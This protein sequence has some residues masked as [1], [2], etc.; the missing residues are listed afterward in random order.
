MPADFHHKIYI[1]PKYSRGQYRALMTTL[2]NALGFET[3]D[4]AKFR[5]HILQLLYTS[6]WKAVHQAFPHVSR[7]TVYRWKK[8]YEGS[9]KRLSSL[10]PQATRPV[11]LRQMQTPVSMVEYIRKLRQDYPR[12]GKDK[13]K[14]FLDVF[15]RENSL[16]PICPTTIGKLIKR[17]NFFF[18]KK[19]SG[20][21]KKRKSASRSRV[22][23]CPKGV[24]LGYLQL[25]GIKVWYTNKYYYLL[26][27][28]EI[29]SRQGF[30][31]AVPGFSSSWARLFLQQVMTQV[32]YPVSV[33]QTD[34]GSEFLA[35]FDQAARELGLT[36]LFSY[37]HC[38][39][40][41]GYVERFNRT[42]KE[43][44]LD[45]NLD[46]LLHP[47]EFSKQLSDWLVYYNQVRPHWSLNLKTPYQFLLEKGVCL[48]S[49]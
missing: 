29:V 20:T 49:V 34:N 40:V 4:R 16:P 36:H 25:D 37:P 47:E 45:F 3:S 21:K 41:Q 15:A 11:H 2:T 1:L 27:A 35:L 31:V 9:Q 8:R 13:I 30:V 5:F 17:Q 38:P 39:K 48:K 33:I 7:P 44:F 12:L 14:L 28:V 22:V 43:E 18:G 10:L 6:G 32:G 42:V 46:L 23:R 26:T 19:G 24:T